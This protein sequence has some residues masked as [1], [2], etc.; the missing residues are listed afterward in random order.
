[1]SVLTLH[2]ESA[3]ST[4]ICFVSLNTSVLSFTHLDSKNGVECEFLVSKI[5]L[6]LLKAMRIGSNDFFNHKV[7]AT[8]PFCKSFVFQPFIV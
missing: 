7:L 3:M 8:K 2:P 1:M 6:G 4:H 5:E